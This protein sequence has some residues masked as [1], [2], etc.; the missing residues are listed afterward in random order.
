MISLFR[1]L[2]GNSISARVKAVMKKRIAEKEKLFRTKCKQISTKY[3]ADL[4][5]LTNKATKDKEDLAD[6]MVAEILK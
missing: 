4:K 5:E 3:F 6:E 1:H 2:F